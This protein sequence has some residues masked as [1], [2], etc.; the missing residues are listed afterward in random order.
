MRIRNVYIGC[1]YIHSMECEKTMTQKEL[2]IL[3]PKELHREFFANV[4]TQDIH[5]SQLIRRWIRQYLEGEKE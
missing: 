4:K 2:H 1:N 5:A 3:I